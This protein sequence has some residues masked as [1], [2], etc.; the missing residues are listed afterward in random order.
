MNAFFQRSTAVEYVYATW[1]IYMMCS[2]YIY[3]DT[4]EIGPFFLRSFSEY[5][6]LTTACAQCYPFTLHKYHI[7]LHIMRTH[8]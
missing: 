8:L 5:V 2:E 3:L 6:L 1:N 7:V 4:L